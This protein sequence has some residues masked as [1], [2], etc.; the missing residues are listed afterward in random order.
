MGISADDSPIGVP[1][2]AACTPLAGRLTMYLIES[3]TARTDDGSCSTTSTCPYIKESLGGEGSAFLDI[4][5]VVASSKK[6][7][8]GCGSDSK[9]SDD[10]MSMIIIIVVAVC[11]V[12]MIAC[13]AGMYKMGSSKGYQ[14]AKD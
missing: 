3:G 14:L 5:D 7:D 13:G 4:C 12:L 9:N 8:Y 2:P 10:S 1:M 6:S 11:V